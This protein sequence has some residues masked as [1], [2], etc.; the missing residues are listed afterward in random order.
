VRKILDTTQ[1]PHRDQH[2]RQGRLARQCLRQRLWRSVKYEEV[3]LRA[4]GSV[5]E[6]RASI[7]RYVDFYNTG[8][9]PIKLVQPAAIPH[10][11]TLADATLIDAEIM[12]RQPE[13]A[14]LHTPELCMPQVRSYEGLHRSR[15]RNC[16]A[17]LRG[18]P[19]IT[20]ISSIQIVCLAQG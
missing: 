2:G 11:L 4:Y 16:R 14:L 12:F 7:G 10:S 1:E 17:E 9:H 19:R 20:S 6:A 15:R 3:Y 13:P 18:I 5:C 8:G